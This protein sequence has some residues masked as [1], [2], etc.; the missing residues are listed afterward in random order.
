MSAASSAAPRAA[1]PPLEHTDLKTWI[2]VLAS[3]MGAFIA[4]LDIQITNSSLKD[5]LGTLSATQEEGSWVSTSY[6]VAEVI[7]IP[8]TGLLARVFG[9]RN[10]IIATT[11]AFL[12]ISSLCGMAWNLPSMIVLRALQG[13]AG[14][15][16]IPMAMTLVMT[17]LPP[18][19]RAVGMA[20][21]GLTGTMA[22]VLGITFGGYL[23]Q[24][25]GWP[26]IFYVNWIPGI[27][28]IAGIAYGLAP[29]NPQLER[30]WHA[31]WFGIAFMALGLGSLTVFLE[32]GNLKDW[33]DSSLIN[34]C[35]A[36]ACI[37]LLGWVLN[38]HFQ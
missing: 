14:G 13:L 25:Y 20:L 4:I 23:S 33:F 26:A 22:P 7:I 2:A 18:T 24:S 35:A 16:L 31:D 37:G 15:G 1:S 5:I 12:L 8:M 38:N 29:V 3:M 27:L 36:L 11:T 28:L 21:F 17:Q 9:V 34:I 30:L 6:L 32:E 19:K 10:Y